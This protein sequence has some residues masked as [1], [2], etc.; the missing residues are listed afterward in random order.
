M[1]SDHFFMSRHTTTNFEWMHIF[2]KLF[3]SFE[4]HHPQ[5]ILKSENVKNSLYQVSK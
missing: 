3:K 5:N 4:T 1:I 2:R